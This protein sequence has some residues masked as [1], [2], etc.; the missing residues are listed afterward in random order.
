M[1]IKKIFGILVILSILTVS[2]ISAQGI[3]EFSVEAGLGSS[4]LRYELYYGERSGG[5]GGAFGVG[6]TYFSSKERATSTGSVYR[7]LWGI[8]TGLGIGLYNAKAKL[9]DVKAE[10]KGLFD[11]DDSVENPKYNE[12]DLR[13]ILHSYTEVQKTVY[14]NIPV[15]ALF[16]RGQFYAMGGP[17]FCIPLSGKFSSKNAS[18]TNEGYYHAMDNT[19]T[20]QEFAGYGTFNRDFKGNFDPGIAVILAL[21]A[22]YKWKIT[23]NLSIY[24]GV[25]FDCGL[26]NTIKESDKAFVNYNNKRPKEF[27]TNSVLSSYSDNKKMTIFTDRTSPMAIGVKLR[28]AMI[29]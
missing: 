26:N 5:F 21:E 6:Y 22:G 23:D 28:F 11:F 3:H 27:T 15:M 25:F 18:L 4:T 14:L 17:K 24:T 29:K 8:H 20:T 1:K 7:N 12:F 19:A 2:V 9:D 13:T 10:T 16:Q